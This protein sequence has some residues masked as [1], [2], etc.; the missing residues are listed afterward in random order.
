M[1]TGAKVIKIFKNGQGDISGI[2]IP[3]KTEP[4]QARKNKN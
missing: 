4:G 2:I 3:G 1:E